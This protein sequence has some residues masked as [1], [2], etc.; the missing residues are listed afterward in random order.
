MKLHALKWLS[1]AALG[2]FS[3]AGCTQTSAPGPV[4]EAPAGSFVAAWSASLDVGKDQIAGIDLCGDLA[5]IRTKKNAA[6]AISA[7]GGTVRWAAQ[8][9]AP[10]RLL[11]APV[12]VGDK[13][14]FPTSGELIV[15]NVNGRREKDIDLDRAIRSPIVTDSGYVYLGFD[16]GTQGRLGRVSIDEPYV[17]V[18]WELMNRGAV[19]AAPAVYQNV[20]YSGSED[21]NVYAVTEERVP[22]WPLPGNVF[23]TG[24]P[25]MADLKA[26]DYAVYVA[27]G[28]SKLYAIDRISGKIKWQHFAGVGLQFSPVISEDSV[29]QFVP[30][31]G[32]VALDKTT[33]AYNREPRWTNDMAVAAVAADAD[34]AY[35]LGADKSIF[36]VD[37]MTGAA[38]F[39]SG[40][41]DLTVVAESRTAG[42]LLVAAT[43][44][45]RIIGVKPVKTG[46]V[47]GELVIAPAAESSRFGG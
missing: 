44:D 22:I 3:L 28:D 13:I 4:V 23:S 6:Y 11:G 34:Y 41:S 16:Y 7:D 24:G 18:R 15:Y 20:I 17:P 12:R 42:G 27:S 1:I 45:G 46:G 14:V 30:G 35:L 29:Y 26:D 19:S 2:L 31:K 25:I 43:R 37:K 10:D 32:V 33:G 5:I 9:L 47:M 39:R 36:A 21:G 38:A 8:I 40:R